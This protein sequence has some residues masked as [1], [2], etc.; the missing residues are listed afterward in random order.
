MFNNIPFL[1]RFSTPLYKNTIAFTGKKVLLM[2]SWLPVAIIFNEHVAYVGKIE[3]S[4]MRPTMNPSSTSLQ[5]WVLLWKFNV[6]DNLKLDDVILFRSPTNP[7]K[8]LCK[9]IKAVQGDIVSTR[10]PYP[11]ETCAIPRNHLWAEGDN[12]HSIDSNNFGPISKGLVI[13]KAT[14]II[15][16]PQRW[17]T[18]ISKGGRECRMSLITREYDDVEEVKT[19]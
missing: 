19:E 16:P 11:R 12:I 3:G 15:W 7:N 18:D 8:V 6:K 1:K 14:R 2:I 10:H 4:S 5:D 17:G 9:R 13:G